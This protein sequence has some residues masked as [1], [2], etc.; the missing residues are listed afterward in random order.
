M[1]ELEPILKYKMSE[2]EAKAYKIAIMWQEE[3]DRELPNEQIVKLKK[4]SDP[5]KSTL[6]KYCYKLAKEMQGVLK[7]SEIQLYIRAQIQI[8]KS[9]RQGQIHALIEPHCLVGE[10]AWTRWKIWKYKHQKILAKALTSEDIEI[11]TSKAKIKVELKKTIDF[12][13]KRDC[14]SLDGLMQNSK[15]I[16]RWVKNGELSCFYIILSPWIRRI[17]GDLEVFDF[18]KIYYRSSISPEVE[19]F[20][21]ETFSHEYI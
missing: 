7:D 1:K 13:K 12:L 8:L 14:I 5:R 18:D 11:S 19:K 16:E 2:M 20:F 9:I 3:C 15:N 10:K 6:F 17:F 4:N 21:K